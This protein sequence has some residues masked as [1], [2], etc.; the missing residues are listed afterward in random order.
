MQPIY[1]LLAALVACDLALWLTFR[2]VPR[3]ERTAFLLAAIIGL[4]AVIVD[5]YF[6]VLQAFH[7]R[8]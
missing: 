2:I 5:V 7:I 3:S 4:L 1:V 6:A 8:L